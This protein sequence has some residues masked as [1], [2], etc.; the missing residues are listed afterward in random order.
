VKA[1]WLG[2]FFPRQPVHR[3]PKRQPTRYIPG[4]PPTLGPAR[5]E[6]P[7][8]PDSESRNSVSVGSLLNRPRARLEKPDQLT[9]A[10]NPSWPEPRLK[11]SQESPQCAIPLRIY[12]SSAAP[13]STVSA[14]ACPARYS[15]QLPWVHQPHWD[16]P[17]GQ[18]KLQ[19][20]QGSAARPGRPAETIKARLIGPAPGR[21][22]ATHFRC[23]GI[24]GLHPAG[25]ARK[26]KLRSRVHRLHPGPASLIKLL[27][28]VRVLLPTTTPGA[29]PLDA[30]HQVHRP[31]TGP[32]GSTL[33]PLRRVLWSSPGRPRTEVQVTIISVSSAPPWTSPP[34]EVT[35]LSQGSTAQ[36]PGQG[37]ARHCD[38]A[39][40]VRFID[41]APGRPGRCF[42]PLHAASRRPSRGSQPSI[43]GHQADQ[44]PTCAM[45]TILEHP[46]S[47][48]CPDIIC[49]CVASG[50]SCL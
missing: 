41:P 32:P 3:A 18:T 20:S 45:I 27:A 36:P 38:Q 31:R 6:A 14:R 17:A 8:P 24:N 11:P 9:R 50:S 43:P 37:S 25:P 47:R 26:F 4:S 49:H 12:A 15:T 39:R 7:N 1:L 35:R 13:S 44:R 34:D 10:C 30:L 42:T 46:P 21:P 2:N 33:S 48:A 16:W 40:Y 5:M 23:A 28:S 22:R 29:G 19:L